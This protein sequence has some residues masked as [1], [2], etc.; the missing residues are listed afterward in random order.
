VGDRPER[1]DL[2]QRVTDPDFGIVAV[3]V[4][5][6][7]G[8]GDDA[9]LVEDDDL[10]TRPDSPASAAIGEGACPFISASLSLMVL[11][12]V[13]ISG[14]L[15]LSRAQRSRLRRAARV[16]GGAGTRDPPDTKGLAPPE[17]MGH[18]LVS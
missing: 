2:D 12:D 15:M 14:R 7:P 9:F 3:D 18:E 4:A 11:D 1:D 13:K 17:P 5:E 6:D 8:I 10:V 16:P